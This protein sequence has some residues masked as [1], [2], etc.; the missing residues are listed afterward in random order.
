MPQGTMW[1]EHRHDRASTFN[2]KPCIVRPRET[3]TADGA[4]LA[5]RRPVR[6]RPRRP[7][8]PASRP[9]LRRPS[10][11][12][13]S[14]TSCL[15]PVDVGRD[16]ARSDRDRHDRIADDLSRPV[17]R[18][19]TTAVGLHELRA[20]ARRLDEHVLGSPAP[21]ACRRAG[22]RGEAGSPR[23]CGGTARVGGRA[24]PGNGRGRGSEPAAV[25]ARM[26]RPSRSTAR[27]ASRVSR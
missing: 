8:Y 22:A 5:W 9:T 27:R 25:R 24:P 26:G 23:R 15:D 20:D 13:A 6:R 19:V 17:V 14:M 2:A 4:D 3:R 18:D 7:G 1:R 12:S 21:R 16:D 10:S 11:P